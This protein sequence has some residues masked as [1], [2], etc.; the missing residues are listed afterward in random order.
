MGIIT[1]NRMENS[2]LMARLKYISA[3]V[4]FIDAEYIYIRQFQAH[5]TEMRTHENC[6]CRFSEAKFN[7]DHKFCKPA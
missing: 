3:W 4:L 2:P 1:F 6:T 5:F 7:P